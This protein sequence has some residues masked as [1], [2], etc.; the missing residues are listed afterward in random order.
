MSSNHPPQGKNDASVQSN[1]LEYDLEATGQGGGVS[2]G[3]VTI[4]LDEGPT[5]WTLIVDN[6]SP[7]GEV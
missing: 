6:T 3:S 7:L 4:C 2:L 5:G 1:E